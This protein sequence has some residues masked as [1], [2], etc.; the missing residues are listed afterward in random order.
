MGL[1]KSD[2]TINGRH[3]Y[4]ILN[5]Q[6]IVFLSI[7]PFT[8]ILM[9]YHK[10]VNPSLF[11]DNGN[12]INPY[13]Y[14]SP[15]YFLSQQFPW[16]SMIW[17][18][19]FRIQYTLPWFSPNTVYLYITSTSSLTFFIFLSG[20]KLGRIPRLFGSI[21]YVI[22]PFYLY[23]LYDTGLIPFFILIPLVLFSILKYNQTSRV[24]FLFLA[25]A[26]TSL[27]VDLDY[28]MQGI[29]AL[30]LIV[31][32]VIIPIIL[33]L[34]V[35]DQQKFTSKTIK[36]Y[37]IAFFLFLSLNIWAIMTVIWDYFNI[38]GVSYHTSSLSISFNSANMAY[39]YAS[40]PLI[41]A[42]S[43][44]WYPFTP[45]FIEF[46]SL[47][48]FLFVLVAVLVIIIKR[49]KPAIKIMFVSMSILFFAL[50]TFSLLVKAGILLPIA[51]RLPVFYLYEYPYIIESIQMVASV[52]LI[53]I[54]IDSLENPNK[55]KR[56][57]SNLFIKTRQ[58]LGGH[59][60]VIASIAVIALLVTPFFVFN[61]SILESQGGQD[62][63]IP[64]YY[65][66]IGEYFDQEKGSYRVLI[67]PLN[68]SSYNAML[69][70]LPPNKLFISEFA[71]VNAVQNASSF[72]NPPLPFPPL[73]EVKSVFL[74]IYS[75][76]NEIA[77]ILAN[78][79]IK[80]VVILNPTQTQN[81]S[82]SQS[83]SG[84]ITLNGGGRNF[85]N[86]FSSVGS[87]KVVASSAQFIILDNNKYSEASKSLEVANN[88]YYPIIV[89]NIVSF[90]LCWIIIGLVVSSEMKRRK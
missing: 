90:S 9:V 57:S 58:M 46:L 62:V 32:I 52:T 43:G 55:I 48:W 34:F 80:Y 1:K 76:N 20:L 60:P 83:A 40:E 74:D 19:L 7:F 33:V 72:L 61:N 66:D 35:N 89:N 84:E 69:M 71:E 23:N 53:S 41:N 77:Y 64:H 29:A 28:S 13:L 65:E 39:N 4:K 51:K 79:N 47:L 82:L 5:K 30:R 81:I 26:V 6:E 88:Y 70:Q 42:L 14:G 15:F 75:K 37:L 10:L 85:M 22:N 2:D 50:M 36:D 25:A 78:D 44:M 45:S 12:F 17:V 56:R 11:F 18:G 38:F 27:I 49:V 21:I 8:V 86:Y 67:L 63:F 73:N 31:P 68:Y 59:L 24:N 54:L 3:C 16:S 87:F